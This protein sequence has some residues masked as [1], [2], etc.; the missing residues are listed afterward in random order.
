MVSDITGGVHAGVLYLGSDQL[1]ESLS[2]ELGFELLGGHRESLR[3]WPLA[4]GYRV[5]VRVIW[6]LLAFIV[7]G[8]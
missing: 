5:L 4:L 1:L 3:S 8:S 6:S 7:S 2:N